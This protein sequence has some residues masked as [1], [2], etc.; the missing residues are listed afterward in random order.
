MYPYVER[1]LSI[2][3]VSQRAE[4]NRVARPTETAPTTVAPLM[5]DTL[6]AC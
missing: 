2:S 4:S 3:L 1:K 5:D 6:T